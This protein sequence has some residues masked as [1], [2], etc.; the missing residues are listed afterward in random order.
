MVTVVASWNA[1][2][3]EAKIHLSL[4]STFFG[5]EQRLAMAQEKVQELEAAFDGQPIELM[6]A[7]A[8]SLDDFRR[9]D[10]RFLDA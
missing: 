6:I 4:D 7:S 2:T 5:R 9:T 3:G 8:R 10:P 1:E